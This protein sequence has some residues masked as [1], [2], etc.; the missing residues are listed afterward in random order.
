MAFAKLQLP[1]SAQAA[2]HTPRYVLDFSAVMLQC[3][4]DKSVD[5]AI[6]HSHQVPG[7]PG[8]ALFDI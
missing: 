8:D 4:A 6:R 3:T 7:P 2:T 1:A 5:R